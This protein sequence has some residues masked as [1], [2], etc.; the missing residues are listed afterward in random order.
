MSYCLSGH[1]ID[2]V[3]L[4]R[5]EIANSWRTERWDSLTLLTPNWQSRLPGY[6]YEGDDP[7]GYRDMPETIAFLER[8]AE[9]ASAPVVTGSN[10]TSVTRDDNGFTVKTDLE[11]WR[12]RSV[13]IASG[14]CNIATVPMVAQGVPSS[15]NSMTAM[16]YRNPDQLPSGGVLIVGASATGT[17][18]SDEIHR[19]GRPVTLAVG[20]HIRAPRVYR[21][22]DIEW[23]MDVTGIHDQGL[24][25][26]DDIKRARRV[27]SFQLTGT[28][29][30]RT[31]DL[32]ALTHIGV[33][34]VGRFA[35]IRGNEAQF[36]G[37]LRNMCKLSDLKM[38]RLLKTVDQ[39][40]LENDFDGEPEPS[41]RLEP[42]MVDDSPRLGLDLASGEV[43]S[44]I[45]ATGYR[46]DYSWLDVPVL[47]RK[48]QIRHAGG[49][50][51]EAPGMY[52][53]GLQFLRRRKSA[54]I[55]G[56]GDDAHDLSVHLASYLDD[57]G[58]NPT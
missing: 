16:D 25:D 37:S 54:L 47:D 23:W 8:Y 48:G 52:L 7:D 13:V 14:A 35:G 12:C 21:G 36:S 49:V 19:S 30:R 3:L 45:W 24:D 2:H 51:T 57:R 58:G 56:V 33:E 11:H 38:N 5:G 20:E 42:T 18:L 44:I 4:E 9:V 15:I 50:I 6:G 34:L 10:V 17:Q 1:S 28:P 32:N 22:R 29:D 27:P 39:W 40:A 46:P 55:D 31:L 41:Q 43:K 26:V 53:L